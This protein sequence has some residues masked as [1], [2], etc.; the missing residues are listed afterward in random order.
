MFSFLFWSKEVN[1]WV[2]GNSTV[3]AE[4]GG[5]YARSPETCPNKVRTNL[6]NEWTGENWVDSEKIKI[7]CDWCCETISVG[8][9][10]D[11]HQNRRFGEFQKYEQL[12]G[13]RVVYYN[14]QVGLDLCG[15]LNN[16]CSV[17][18]LDDFFTLSLSGFSNLF[19]CIVFD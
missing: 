1:A 17:K 7:R 16:R 10:S 18:F 4:V 13:E 19:L 11:H 12:H 9:P 8:G 14:K 15:L 2:G 3:Q 5:F 6:W